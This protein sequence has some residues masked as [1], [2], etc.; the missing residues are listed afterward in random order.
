MSITAVSVGMALL[1]FVVG[2]D[3]PPGELSP[4]GGG[5]VAFGWRLA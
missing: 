3:A 5:S 4:S 2:T 1:L